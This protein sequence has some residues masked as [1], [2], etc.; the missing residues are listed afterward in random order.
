MGAAVK[1]RIAIVAAATT[2]ALSTPAEAGYTGNELL[3]H[4]RMDGG[5]GT[6]NS[7]TAWEE[8]LQIGI[9]YGVIVALMYHAPSADLPTSRFCPPE[10]STVRQ[11][12][13]VVV[14]ALN[15]HPEALHLN[16]I[17]LAHKALWKAWPCGAVR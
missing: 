16:F 4:C 3:P 14:K 12:V 9:C 17:S 13:S 1:A 10:G 11:G 7:N 5:S 6:T 2:L 15:E 8:G